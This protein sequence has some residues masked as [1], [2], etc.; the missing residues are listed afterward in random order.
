M[1]L[2]NV[3]VNYQNNQVNSGSPGQ[4]GE[5]ISIG[6]IKITAKIGVVFELK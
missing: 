2:S 4:T 1:S 3:S 6:Q 5:T